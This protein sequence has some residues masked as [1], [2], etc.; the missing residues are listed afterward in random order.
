MDFDQ[1]AFLAALLK[2]FKMDQ[3]DADHVCQVVADCFIGEDE[4]NDEDLDKET[5]AMFY[6]LEAEGLMTFRRTEYKFEG[7]I[8]RAFFWRLTEDVVAGNVANAQPHAVVSEEEEVRA[9][10]ATLESDV[11]SRGAVHA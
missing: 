1:P 9:L 8:R 5:R 3:P 10:Y 4:V 7:A 2:A 11:W 6:A